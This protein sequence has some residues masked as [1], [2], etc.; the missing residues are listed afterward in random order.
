MNND[1]VPEPIAVPWALKPLASAQTALDLLPN[2]GMRMEI[3]HDV[4]AGVTPEMLLWWFQNMQGT[5]RVEGRSYPRYRVWHPRDHVAFRYAKRTTP[6]IGAGAVF[7]IH[8]LFGADPAFR[9]DVLSDVT[10]LDVGGFTHMP[11]R[12]F[13]HP[14]T[15]DYRFIRVPGGTRYENSLTVSLPFASSVPRLH[16]MIVERAFSEAHG[17]AWLLHN[18]E[19]VGSFEQFLPALHASAH[20]RDI[21]AAIRFEAA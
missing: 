7:A 21:D 13:G 1:D 15:M 11:R 4:L 3:V 6:E 14:V 5:M 12:F 17:R 10:R 20:G 18:V 8:E 19:E 16:R 2:G 9:I